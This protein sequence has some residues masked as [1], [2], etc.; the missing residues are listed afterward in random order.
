MRVKAKYQN[1]LT[2]Y[3]EWITDN[4]L[5]PKFEYDENGISAAEAM[6]KWETHGQ[7]LPIAS[8]EPN[9]LAKYVQGKTSRDFYIK[10]WKEDIRNEWL[11][12]EE[13][14]YT[15]GFNEVEFKSV[16][17]REPNP[18][19]LFHFDMFKEFMRYTEGRTESYIKFLR[20]AIERKGL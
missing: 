5:R 1:A 15:L 17:G 13:L 2:H 9:L 3:L 8:S 18:L 16:F 7:D 14:L 19:I 20:L 4:F 11:H 10:N 6:L 12:S